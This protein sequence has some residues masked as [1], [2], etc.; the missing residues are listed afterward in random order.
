M[1]LS[2]SYK[3]LYLFIYVCITVFFAKTLLLSSEAMIFPFLI[4]TTLAVLTTASLIR[5]M[6]NQSLYRNNPQQNDADVSVQDNEISADGLRR[7]GIFLLWLLLILLGGYYFSF[8][9]AI[10]IW[11][12]CYLIFY[13][14]RVIVSFLYTGL[15]WIIL[16]EIFYKR[17]YISLDQGLWLNFF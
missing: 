8:L 4:L 17:L 2:T 6:K 11:L 16:Y 14:H 9:I 1:V 5:N 7:S 10:P 12:F 13:K 15:F 3:L